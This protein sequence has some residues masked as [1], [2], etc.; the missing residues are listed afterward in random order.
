MRLH[1]S[2]Q[3]QQGDMHRSLDALKSIV[4]NVDPGAGALLEKGDAVEVDMLGDRATSRVE[5]MIAQMQ[6]LRSTVRCTHGHV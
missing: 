5:S 4:A 1:D 2:L 6:E 3:R